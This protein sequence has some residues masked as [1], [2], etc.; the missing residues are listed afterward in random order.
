MK[1]LGVEL[2]IQNLNYIVKKVIKTIWAK[3]RNHVYLNKIHS[4]EVDSDFF[5]NFTLFLN[6]VI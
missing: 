1:I 6:N 4:L 2:S 5:Y 3:T